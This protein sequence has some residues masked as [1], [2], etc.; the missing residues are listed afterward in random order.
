VRNTKLSRIDRFLDMPWDERRSA[1]AFKIKKFQKKSFSVIPA[2][3]R[4]DPG[5]LF[6][7]WDDAIRD[8]ILSGDFEKTERHFVRRFLQPGMTVLDV[9]AYFGIYSLTASLKVGKT[10]HVIAFEPSPYQRRRLRWHLRLNLCKNVQVEAIALGNRDGDGELFVPTEGSEGF[11]SLRPPEVPEPLGRLHVPIMTLDSYLRK[12]PLD[13]ID[14]IKVD[15]EGGELDFFKGADT[16]LSGSARP[17]ILCEL[18]DVRSATWGHTA[19][20]A[21]SFLRNFG[22]RWFALL[23]DANLSRMPAN[24]IH[25]EGN[26]VAIPEERLHQVQEMIQDGSRS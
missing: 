18:Q 22:F 8:A 20:D 3:R 6:L 9:G 16:L 19:N 17:V 23:P 25:Y 10:G 26:F 24:T 7:V 12:H 1:I 21:A 14:L 11:S 2:V 5:F 15:V 4:I 13:S